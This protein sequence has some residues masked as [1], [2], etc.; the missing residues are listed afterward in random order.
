[1]R[2]KRG[3]VLLLGLGAVLLGLW[4][5]AAGC[6][7]HL[8]IQLTGSEEMSVE[9]GEPFSDPG[10][11]AMVYGDRFC[12]EGIVPRQLEIQTS[13]TVDLEKT[14]KYV[15]TYTARCFGMEVST[16][17][18][19][20]VVDTR[21]PEI[22]LTE[23]DPD[24]VGIPYQE[25]GYRAVDNYD[26]D[27]T[28]RVIRTEEY[29]VITYAVVDSS[30]NPAYAQREI[31]G[32]DTKAP[33][34][35][36]EGET[37]M[38]I[39]VGTFYQEPGYTAVDA[40]EGDVT[41]LVSVS[42]EVDWLRPGTYAVTYTVSDSAE[43]T[44]TATRT[45]TVTAKERPKTV[46]PEKKVIYLT[47]D[48][49]PGPDTLRLL[50]ILDAYGVKATFF[51]TDSGYPAA[52]KE[53]VDRGHS[54]GIHT[55]THKYDQVYADAESYFRDLYQIREVI[56][57]ATGVETTLL[58]FPGGSSNTISKR[59]CQGLMSQLVE[60]VQD[61]GFQYFDWNVDSDDAGHARR[62]EMVYQNVTL[63]IA[64]CQVAVVLQHDV[65]RYSVDAVEDIIVWGLNNG[66]T[67]QALNENSPG[68]HHSVYN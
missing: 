63:G 16:R 50:D 3:V 64:A 13:D 6:Q 20:R 9:Y 32:V 53:I 38:T 47:F 44:A 27:I 40:V 31:P 18:I 14:G 46:W 67:F 41:E 5:Y 21:C 4:W 42:G 30:G 7:W 68:M 56:R 25:A 22:Y 36:L 54:I 28:H 34:L 49:G 8:E 60:A 10:A 65:H 11:T 12:R 61:A 51:V 2:K 57:E 55:A 23:D 29:G 19:L 58:R 66:Y 48:D 45:V 52:M 24:K 17:R 33:Q 26:G 62:K 59:T 37:E 43:N 15:I 1:M 35:L 39:P